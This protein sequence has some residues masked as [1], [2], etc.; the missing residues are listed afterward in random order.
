MEIHSF[1]FV[2]SGPEMDWRV[3]NL[4]KWTKIN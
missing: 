4:V 2:L 3:F 1:F